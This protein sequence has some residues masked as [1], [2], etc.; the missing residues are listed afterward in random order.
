MARAQLNAKNI[1]QMLSKQMFVYSSFRTEQNRTG[2]AILP[3]T[4]MFLYT[5]IYEH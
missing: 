2:S 1:N 3:Y 4:S 5:G